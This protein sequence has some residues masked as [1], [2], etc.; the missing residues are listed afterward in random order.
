MQGEFFFDPYGPPS[1]DLYI[2]AVRPSVTFFIIKQNKAGVINDPH[3]KRPTV[4]FS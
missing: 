1:I 3:G 2:V 4:I